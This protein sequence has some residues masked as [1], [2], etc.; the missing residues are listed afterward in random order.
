MARALRPARLTAA[1]A[2]SALAATAALPLGAAAAS[3]APPLAPGTQR[4]IFVGNNWDGTTDVVDP[5]TFE[6][7]KR[8]NVIPDIEERMAEIM[9]DP[10]RLGYFLAIRQLVGEGHD[11]Y[12]DDVF[13]SHDGRFMYV[14]RPSLAD[15]V[16]IDLDTEQIVWRIPMEGQRSDHMGISPDGTRLLVSDSTARKVHVIDPVAGEVVGE[17]ESGDTP[18]EN[19]YTKDGTRIFHASIG[20]VYT[21]ADRPALD[22]TKG[23]RW[24]QIVDAATNEV[25]TRLDIGQVA[26]ESG[27]ADRELSSAVRPMAISPDEKTAYLQ[28]SFHHGFVELDLETQKITRVADLPLTEA[29]EGVPREQY[30]LDS[31]HHGLALNPDGTKLCAA[32]TMSDYAAIVHVDDFAYTLASRGSKPYWSTNSADGTQCYVSY[33]GD[34]EVAVIDYATEKEIARFPVGDHPQRVRNGLIRT[35]FLQQA[36]GAAPPPAAGAPTP[37]PAATPA[38]AGRVA[39]RSLAATGNEIALPAALLLLTTAAAGA[40]GRRRLV[41]RG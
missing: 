5:V 41:R 24:F 28:L 32:G 13:T 35:E 30:L 36:P 27:F 18:H 26:D 40:L 39:T 10:E 31:A 33:S 14:S 3:Q 19:N 12:N 25:L 6:R 17:F 7:L 29:S 20:T 8:I 22:S 34:D 1:L 2:V 38:A 9:T 4:A 21:P 11:Q 23:D 15:V 37:A 16:S